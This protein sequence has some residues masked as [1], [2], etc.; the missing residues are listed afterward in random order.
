[1]FKNAELVANFNNTCDEFKD[2]VAQAD[3]A[4]FGLT[5]LTLE[6]L[7]VNTWTF[8]EAP[9]QTDIR[10]HKLSN[11]GVTGVFKWLG[12]MLILMLVSVFL[13]VPA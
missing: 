11:S 1:M 5:N 10:W 8:E 9:T 12:S 2:L 7:K 3:E 4:S 13:L 6:Q